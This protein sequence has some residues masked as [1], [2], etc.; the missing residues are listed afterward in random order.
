MP[1]KI[2]QLTWSFLLHDLLSECVL[3]KS[4]VY[5]IRCVSTGLLSLWVPPNTSLE[6]CTYDDG[7]MGKTSKILVGWQT[8]CSDRNSRLVW[9]TSCHIMLIIFMYLCSAPGICWLVPPFLLSHS[10]TFSCPEHS[11]ELQWIAL[12]QF[13]LMALLFT[14]AYVSCSVSHTFSFLLLYFSSNWPAI[15]CLPQ[16][17]SCPHFCCSVCRQPYCP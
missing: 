17:F 6:K 14:Q 5:N 1:N 8:N 2:I 10:L 13:L 16:L 11:A 15:I 12:F 4:D 9:W 7:R 3:S